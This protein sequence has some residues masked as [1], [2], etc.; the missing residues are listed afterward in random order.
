MSSNISHFP[1]CYCSHNTQKPNLGQ[2]YTSDKSFHFF[3]STPAVD[4]DSFISK[5]KL[6][7]EYCKVES[8]RENILLCRELET[9]V[10]A[11]ILSLTKSTTPCADGTVVTDTNELVTLTK[12]SW[13]LQLLSKLKNTLIKITKL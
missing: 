3:Q 9:I 7:D 10:D 4:V 1:S 6:Y 2:I 5:M 11:E 8:F 13:R 12:S